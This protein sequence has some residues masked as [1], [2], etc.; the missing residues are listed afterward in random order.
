MARVWIWEKDGEVT[1]NGKLL[2]DVYPDPLVWKEILGPF[3]AN[4]TPVP[5]FTVSIKVQGGGVS[6]QKTAIMMGLARALEKYN[7]EFRSALK[8]REYL[9]R[10]SREVERK[11]YYLKKARKR[12]QYSKR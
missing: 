7:P 5:K 6:S 9:T 12:P 4:A 2:K 11:K 1:V 8:K 3:Y 10:D